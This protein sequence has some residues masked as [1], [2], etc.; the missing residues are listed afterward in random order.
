MVA[1]NVLR[2][3]A[4]APTSPAA[5]AAATTNDR[6][7]Q[8]VNHKTINQELMLLMS[9]LCRVAHFTLPTPLLLLLLLLLLLPVLLLVLVILGNM[10]SEDKSNEKR[11]CASS[12]VLFCRVASTA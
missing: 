5:A 1:H 9:T 11:L 6:K 4:N 3:A 8:P 10:T 7:Y 2:V 12:N